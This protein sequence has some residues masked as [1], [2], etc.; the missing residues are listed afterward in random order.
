[1]KRLPRGRIF[2]DIVLEK[3]SRLKDKKHTLLLEIVKE[4]IHEIN[5]KTGQENDPKYMAYALEY[6]FNLKNWRK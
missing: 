3:A 1:M 4:H 6:A 2:P 5:E